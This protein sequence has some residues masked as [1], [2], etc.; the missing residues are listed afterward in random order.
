VEKFE[1]TEYDLEN[2]FN[3]NRPTRRISKNKQIYGKPQYYAVSALHLQVMITRFIL[4]HQYVYTV[5]YWN[6]FVCLCS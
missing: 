4:I 5:V 3:I 1:V 6:I 2:E